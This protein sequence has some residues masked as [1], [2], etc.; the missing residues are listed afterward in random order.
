[1]S[2]QITE[3]GE[4]PTEVRKQPRER[5]MASEQGFRFGPSPGR[6]CQNPRQEGKMENVAESFVLGLER[7]FG[8]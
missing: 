6:G 7:F 1:M 5:T 4:G 2:L 8:L 3:S